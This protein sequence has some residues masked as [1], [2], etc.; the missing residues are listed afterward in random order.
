VN[1]NV[2]PY[3]PAT[4]ATTLQEYVEMSPVWLGPVVIEQLVMPLTPVMF[5][6]PAGDGATATAGEAGPATVAIK[7]MVEPSGALDALATTVTVGVAV[8]TEVE[9]P[10]AGDV[11]K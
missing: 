7:V 9:E 10:D 5:H 11:A 4:E 2:A 8:L 1:T 3:V 6:D